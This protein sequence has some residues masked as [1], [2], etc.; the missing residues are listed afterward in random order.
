ML[1]PLSSASS[2]EGLDFIKV[3]KKFQHTLLSSCSLTPQVI[4]GMPYVQVQVLHFSDF[5]Y[6]LTELRSASG[7][8]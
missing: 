6:G 2:K 3:H 5:Y 1:K 4:V 7:F 8:I